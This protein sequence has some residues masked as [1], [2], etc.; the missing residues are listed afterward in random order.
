MEILEV[1]CLFASMFLTLL[2]LIIT[3]NMMIYRYTYLIKN[4]VKS[5]GIYTMI[6]IFFIKNLNYQMRLNKE[7]E[8]EI[9]D[10]RKRD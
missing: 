7:E 10:L 8:E 3:S 5:Y 9:D 4:T 2:K 6:Y 1:K